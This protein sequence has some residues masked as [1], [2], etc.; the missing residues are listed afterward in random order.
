MGSEGSEV[1]LVSS[2]TAA[3]TA[4]SGKLSHP[5]YAGNARLQKT[6]TTDFLTHKRVVNDGHV[7]Q[8]T[9]ETAPGHFV[10]AA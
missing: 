2:I 3:A 4:V 7:Q 10:G 9:W 6:V 1:Y 5:D 8:F